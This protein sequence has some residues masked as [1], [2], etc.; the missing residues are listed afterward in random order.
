MWP[1][2]IKRECLRYEFSKPT[3]IIRL[4][5]EQFSQVTLSVIHILEIPI[6]DM[7]IIDDNKVFVVILIKYLHK[8]IRFINS[9]ILTVTVRS[10]Y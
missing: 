9:L 6:I 2:L 5:L 3:N 7:A 4:F 8:N 10:V 1:Y